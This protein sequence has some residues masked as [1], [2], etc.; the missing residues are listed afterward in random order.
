LKYPNVLWAISQ[1]GD[2]YKFAAMIGRS[3]SWLSRRLLG[4]VEFK[5]DEREEIAKALGY[6]ADWLFQEPQP[7]ARVVTATAR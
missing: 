1:F 2:R 5:A 6:P 7:P 3:E 4:R